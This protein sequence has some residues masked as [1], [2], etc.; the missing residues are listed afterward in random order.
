MML[1]TFWIAN[2][3]ANS[4]LRFDR[5]LCSVRYGD[6]TTCIAWLPAAHSAAATMITGRASLAISP[7][8]AT[9]PTNSPAANTALRPTRS[10]AALAGNATRAPATDAMVATTP[11]VAVVSLSDER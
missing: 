3:I 7:T 2:W 5:S 6:S 1:V 9:R 10:D 8:S 11:I 4:S